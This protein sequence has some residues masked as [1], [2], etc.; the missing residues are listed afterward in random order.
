MAHPQASELGAATSVAN[1]GIRVEAFSGSADEWDRFAEQQDGYTHYHKL[2]WRGVMKRAF[3]HDGV[4]LAARDTAGSLVGVLPLIRMRSMLFGRQLCSMPFLN[5]GGPIGSD[6]AIRALTVA[7][8]AEAE[9][10]GTK[11]LEFR[12]RRQLPIDLPCSTH[13]ITVTIDL[14]NTGSKDFWKSLPSAV[15]NQVRKPQKAGV[16][17]RFG[18]DQM[19][20]FFD[21]FARNMRD[22]GTPTH[23]LRL[24]AEIAKEFPDD[25]IFGCAYVDGTPVAGGCAIKWGNELEMVWGSALREYNKTHAPNMLMYWSFMERACELGMNVFNF[26]RCTANEGTHRFKRQWGGQDDQLYWYGPHVNEL[27][28]GSTAE[29]LGPKVWKYLPL[30]IANLIGPYVRRGISA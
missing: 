11:T 22:L 4:Y 23:P 5:Y 10:E 29:R 2:G 13:K 19:K 20:P 18:A 24:F 3:G 30:P 25:A 28:H 15:R 27:A 16:T 21:V 1:G 7:A 14:S 9:R 8:Q 6:A 26:G 17:M 12:A